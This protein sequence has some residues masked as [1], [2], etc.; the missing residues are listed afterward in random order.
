MPITLVNPLNEILPQ[1]GIA[2]P[3]LLELKGKTIALLDISKP[4]GSIFLDRIERLLKERHGVASV[5]RE[6]KPTFAKPAPSGIIENIRSADAVIEA[7][8]D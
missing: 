6:M 3:R 5:I 4:G 8:A 2:A 1:A 7:L